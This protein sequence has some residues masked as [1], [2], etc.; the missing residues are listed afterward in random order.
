LRNAGLDPDLR[1]R[2][3]NE[4]RKI[5]R[6]RESRVHRV[7]GREVDVSER[8]QERRRVEQIRSLLDAPG[9]EDT[10]AGR[11]KFAG[12]LNERRFELGDDREQV[13]EPRRILRDLT[14]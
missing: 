4:A 12:A 1:S 13:L 14:S 2:N 5:S 10:V 6:R 3:G 9:L 8:L 11:M 7:E